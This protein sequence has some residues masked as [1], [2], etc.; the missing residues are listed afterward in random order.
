MGTGKI[1][2]G[3]IEWP[4]GSGQYLNWGDEA[5]QDLVDEHPQW[6]LDKPISAAEIDE[7][8]EEELRAALKRLTGGGESSDEIVRDEDGEEG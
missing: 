8:P 2:G 7:M 1:A 6:V 3:Q 5:P 4:E